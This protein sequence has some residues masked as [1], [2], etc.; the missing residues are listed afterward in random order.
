MI[1][2]FE[3]NYDMEYWLTTYSYMFIKG[4]GEWDVTE[5]ELSLEYSKS[6]CKD[7]KYFIEDYFDRELDINP[8][9]IHFNEEDLNELEKYCNAN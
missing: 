4:Q 9:Y 8:D 3:Y 7:F 6:K 1:I 5:D 2:R